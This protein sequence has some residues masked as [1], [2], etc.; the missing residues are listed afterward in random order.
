LGAIGGEIL[1]AARTPGATLELAQQIAAE[2]T[3]TPWA[4]TIALLETEEGETLVAGGATP[5][6]AA[7]TALAENLGLTVA[8]DTAGLHAEEAVIKAAGDLGLT[9]TR[10]VTTNLICPTCAST[11]REIGGWVGGRVFIFGGP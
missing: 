10:G 1:G 5:L 8:D 7:Q 9:P 4:R 6:S 2:G 3:S 11:I